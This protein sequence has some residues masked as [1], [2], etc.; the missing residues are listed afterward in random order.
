VIK[1]PRHSVHRAVEKLLLGSDFK[2]VHVA[3][4]MPAMLG[5][6]GHRRF[7]HDPVSAAL[8]G[9]ALHG[10]G[11]ALSALLH[12]ALDQACN[13]KNVRRLVRGLVE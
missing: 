2:D 13:D 4:D 12:I 9:Y 1:I 11:G 8:I 3:L 5:V 7:F 10:S 6:K